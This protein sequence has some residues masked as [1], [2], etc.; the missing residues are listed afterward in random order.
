MY[1]TLWPTDG[2]HGYF[3]WYEPVVA[4][5]SLL[6]LAALASFLGIAYVAKRAGRPL[7]PWHGSARRPL[8]ETARSL[9]AASLLVFLTQETME[10][11]LEAGHPTLPPLMPSQWLALLAGI[12]LTSLT[13]AA[14]ISAG[15]AATRS[16]LARPVPRLA[17]RRVRTRTWTV[18][19]SDLR[20]RRPLAAR[21]ALRA[22][23]HFL[24]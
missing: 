1:R 7:R 8:A 15:E 9:S 16:L 21:F 14:A 3:G 13:L 5:A 23:P 18:T 4:A 20:A 2:A 22:P 19:T 24:H 17:P 12:T 11:S 6:S 10:R